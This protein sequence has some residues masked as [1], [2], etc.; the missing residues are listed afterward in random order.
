MPAFACL[1]LGLALGGGMLGSAL[2][3]SAMTLL[4]NSSYAMYIL[5]VP[6]EAALFALFANGFGIWLRGWAWL[7]VYLAVLPGCSCL[8]YLRFERPANR[9]LRRRLGRRFR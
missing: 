3:G 2:S 7:A 1:M 4:G 6:V 5:H 8:V 9:A